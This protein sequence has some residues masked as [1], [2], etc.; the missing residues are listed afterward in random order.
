MLPTVA[1]LVGRLRSNCGGSATVRPSSGGRDD[2]PPVSIVSELDFR[3]LGSALKRDDSMAIPSK[4]S[5]A[6]R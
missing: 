6:G 2:H 5:S 1:L 4:S 3:A